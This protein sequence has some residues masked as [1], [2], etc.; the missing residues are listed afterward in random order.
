MHTTAFAI[1]VVE[2]WL[3][4]EMAQWVNDE[5]SI[6][7][8]MCVLPWSYISLLYVKNAMLSSSVNFILISQTIIIFILLKNNWI[9]TIFAN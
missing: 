7:Q 6:Q 2:H 5:G 3:E 1:P 9:S 4:Q 8:P